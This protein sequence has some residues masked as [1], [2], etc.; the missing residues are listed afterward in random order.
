ML[1]RLIRVTF[2]QLLHRAWRTTFA[3][4]MMVVVVLSIRQ[5]LADSFGRNLAALIL[6]SALGAATYF[7]CLYIT[8]RVSGRPQGAETQALD[9]VITPLRQR[10]ARRRGTSAES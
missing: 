9:I 6:Y 7:I 10:L 2:G 3:T 1:H 5:P 8:W 4:A